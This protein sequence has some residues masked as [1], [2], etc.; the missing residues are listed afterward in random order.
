MKFLTTHFPSHFIVASSSLG[1][2][3][4]LSMGAVKMKEEIRA[5]IPDT[6][7]QGAAK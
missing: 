6:V 3:I 7:V 4:L 1:L 2:N 5:V